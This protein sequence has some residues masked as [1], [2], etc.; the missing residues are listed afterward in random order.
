MNW[1][2]V[3]TQITLLDDSNFLEFYV[4]AKKST[5][6]AGGDQKAERLQNGGK[7]YVFYDR[8]RWPQWL[9][10]DI[11]HGYN[12][13]FGNEII[14]WMENPS[15]MW[16]PIAQM[17]YNGYAKGNEDQIKLLF[18]FLESMLQRVCVEDPFRGPSKPIRENGL[19]YHCQWMRLDQYRVEGKET[20]LAYALC[21]GEQVSYKLNFQFC[22]LPLIPL[23]P[24]RQ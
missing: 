18:S 2:T 4:T 21:E 17:S 19:K 12:P 10:R 15:S 1:E 7:M 8:K 13:F 11:Y 22:C 23:I 16:V 24:F 5:Y 3:M 20:I 14:E 6:A 9:Y